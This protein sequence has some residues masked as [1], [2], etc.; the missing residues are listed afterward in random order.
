[1]WRTFAAVAIIIAVAPV[2]T[3][4]EDAQAVISEA[5]RAMGAT[6]LISVA[7]SGSAAMGNFGQSKNISFRLAST[8]IRN[9]R[10]A[11]DFSQPASLATGDAFPPAVPGGVPPQPRAYTQTIS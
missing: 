8:S 6:A 7:Y 2:S 3:V 1:M 11:I 10:L 4:A 5:S 9:Y